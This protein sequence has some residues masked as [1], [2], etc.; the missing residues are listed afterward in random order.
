[1]N[2]D[3]KKPGGNSVHSM[4]DEYQAEVSQTQMVKSEYTAIKASGNFTS[5]QVYI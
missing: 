5:I 4:N 3:W 1:V 2:Q